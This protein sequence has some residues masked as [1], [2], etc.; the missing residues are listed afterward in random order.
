MENTPQNQSRFFA[1][2][3]GVKCLYVGGRGLF[4]VGNGGWNLRHPDFFLQLTPLSYI[5]DED[6]IDVARIVYERPSVKFEI[7]RKEDI[8][9]LTYTDNVQIKHHVCINFKYAT[10]NC[11]VTIPDVKT[12]KP[13][14]FKHNIGE[15][16]LSAKNVIAYI[17]V[18]DFLREK[19]YAVPFSNLSV[20]KLQ[21]YGWI[22]L[23]S[24]TNGS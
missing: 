18:I 20:Q 17:Q 12:D 16:G 24:N 22:K 6:A 8:M 3:W 11:N 7:D 19:G 1:Q 4:E 23:K 2:Y 14:M 13:K 5:T 21:E 10:L 9:H 15:I